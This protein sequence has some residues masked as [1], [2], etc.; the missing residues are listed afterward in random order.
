MKMLNILT[1]LVTGS[2][3]MFNL[4]CREF[5]HRKRY[6][7]VTGTVETLINAERISR[8][9]PG[10]TTEAEVRA[11]FDRKLKNQWTFNKR[12]LIKEFE[13]KKYEIDKIHSYAYVPAFTRSEP[14]FTMY[15]WTDRIFLV[16]FYNS[17]IVQFYTVSHDHRT[18]DDKIVNGELHTIGNEKSSWPG[19]MCDLFFYDYFELGKEIYPSAKK[20]CGFVD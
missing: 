4:N 2:V 19:Q 16:V 7:D 6:G 5:I 13:G 15:G 12:K 8:I 20:R 14:G 3:F 11:I 9:I 18:E 1:V 10:K 17:G